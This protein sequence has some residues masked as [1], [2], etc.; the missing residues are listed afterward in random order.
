[1]K[2]S[3]EALARARVGTAEHAAPVRNGDAF[4]P[5][6]PAPG[7]LPAGQK[8]AMDSAFAGAGDWLGAIG[9]SLYAE[10]QIFLGYPELAAMAQRPEYRVISET[11]AQEMTRE[12]IEFTTAG[13]DNKADRIKEIED[14]LTRLGVQDLL[15]VT[16]EKDGFFGR[17][18]IFV[19][20][21]DKFEDPEL[22]LDIG[23]GEDAIS[24]AKV[25]NKP[26]K[27]LKS[28]EASWTYPANYNASNP[29]ADD[30]YKPKSWY[31]MGR[32]I[33]ASRLLTFV[34]REVP[35]MLKP[36]Y[37][38]GGLP[39]SQMAKPY[40]DNWLQTRQGV[41]DIIQA[42]SVFVLATD[43]SSVMDGGAGETFYNRLDIFS[44]TRNNRGVMALN[45]DTE[46]FKNVSAPLG[47]LDALQAQSQEHMASVSKLPLVKMTGISPSGLNASSDGELRCHGD[48]IK[49]N[50]ETLFRPNLTKIIN[51]IQLSLWGEV[52]P[53]I[54]FKFRSIYQLSEKEAAEVRKIEAETGAILIDDGALAP[55]EE[56]ERVAKDPT[57]P[58]QG[59]DL[60]DDPEIPGDGLDPEADAGE[61]GGLN[62]LFDASKKA[63]LDRHQSRGNDVRAGGGRG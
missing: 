30:W 9:A 50:Q 56:R 57:T 12:W 7:V 40:V 29:L 54:G 16:A 43:M 6:Q 18:H 28:V 11:I 31:V 24:L 63:D 27:A 37:C 42:F 4:A 20:Y 14:E 32:E 17:H 52:D 51:L 60:N 55:H 47:T 61:D 10:G 23:D 41:N 48:N 62:S 45:K 21:G 53:A 26:I 38:F 15:R 49:A 22:Q 8:I 13:D 39:M 36:A 46:D 35:D 33:H 58:Y 5:Y 25:R 3:P 2:I 34:G 59:L 1:M 19:D 44:A